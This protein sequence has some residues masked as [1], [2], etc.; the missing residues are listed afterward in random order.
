MN[1]YRGLMSNG[2]IANFAS[3]IEYISEI[4]EVKRIRFT[5]SHPNEMNDHLID[6]FGNIKKLAN[7][8]SLTYSIWFRQSI[9]GNEE[10]LHNFGI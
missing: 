8:P 5:T 3:L 7:Q 4:E 2:K 1:G 6:C 10:E 9:D